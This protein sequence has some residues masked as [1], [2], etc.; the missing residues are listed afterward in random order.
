MI[1]DGSGQRTLQSEAGERSG[2][3]EGVGSQICRA[4]AERDR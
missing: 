2:V 1:I 4:C 3:V